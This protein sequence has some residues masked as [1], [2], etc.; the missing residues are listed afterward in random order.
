M[1]DIDS[2]RIRRLVCVELDGAICLIRHSVDAFLLTRICCHFREKTDFSCQLI[3]A[4]RQKKI[5]VQKILKSFLLNNSSTNTTTQHFPQIFLATT[6][7][8]PSQHSN[9][10]K[11]IY[12]QYLP[13]PIHHFHSYP[14]SPPGI[15][16]WVEQDNTPKERA[17]SV[18]CCIR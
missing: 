15:P 14:P 12:R 11:K 17:L 4:N 9:P 7:E 10:P 2:L 18:T 6:H 13:R 1:V 16:R 3:F 5:H 8:K